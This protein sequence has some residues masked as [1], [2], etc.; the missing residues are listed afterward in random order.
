MKV[1]TTLEPSRRNNLLILFLSGLLFWSSLASLLPTLPLYVEH[2]GGT[3]QQIGL[4]MG[5]FALGLLPSRAWFGPLA[6]RHGRRI[7]ILVGA[8]VAAS[9][10]LGYLLIDQISGLMVLRAYHGISI[11]AFTIGYSALVTD[12]S[13]P[14]KRGEVVGYMSLVN[15]IGVAIGPAVGGFLLEATG[16]PPLFLMAA[17]LGALSLVCTTQVEDVAEPLTHPSDNQTQ[18]TPPNPQQSFWQ[19]LW[20]PRVRIPALVMLLIGIVFGTLSTFVPLFI[21][22]TGV[23]LN[24]GWFYTAAAISSFS[25]RILTG[26]ASDRYGRGL[27]I[28]ASLIGYT[29]SMLTLWTAG[30]TTAF[31]IAGILEG[32]ASGTLL[33]MMIVLM[34]DRCLPQERGRYFALC[35]GGFDFGLAVAGPSLGTIA[36]FAGYRNMFALAAGMATVALIIF[37]TL[38]SKSISHSFRFALG[39]ERDIYAMEHPFVDV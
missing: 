18:A 27:F 16:Y 9:A 32:A 30:S 13:P 4:V 31:L 17:G 24:P 22:Q 34:S 6:D 33:P 14:D 28:T 2:I 23:A 21:K 11:A 12:L 15:P 19:L 20:N 29:L 1:L 39:K 3:K 38:S 10:P 5:A 7:V 25:I 36:E 26:R 8:G 35:V 37:L